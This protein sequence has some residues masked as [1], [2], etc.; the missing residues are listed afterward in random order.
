[1]S[2]IHQG[3]FS[4]PEIINDN[5][6]PFPFE[7][8]PIMI[9]NYCVSTQNDIVFEVNGEVT[10]FSKNIF[11][12]I[13]GLENVNEVINFHEDGG[14][15]VHITLTITV[16]ETPSIELDFTTP[17]LTVAIGGEVNVQLQ[18][19]ENTIK[20]VFSKQGYSADFGFT[21]YVNNVLLQK[22][23]IFNN[24]NFINHLG[25]RF[26]FDVTLT[27]GIVSGISGSMMKYDINREILRLPAVFRN[28]KLTLND[29]GA[30]IGFIT[31][32]PMD[33][34][35]FQTAGVINTNSYNVKIQNFTLVTTVE[36]EIFPIYIALKLNE[37]TINEI[38]RFFEIT[39]V[40]FPRIP[41]SLK[42]PSVIWSEDTQRLPNGTTP[43]KGLS[44]SSLLSFEN[45]NIFAAFNHQG[46]TLDGFLQ[47][48]GPIHIAIDNFSLLELN[49]N[50]QKLTAS[51]ASLQDIPTTNMAL[52][53]QKN[54]PE[55]VLCNPGGAIFEADTT[56]GNLKANGNLKLFGEE[57]AILD[58]IIN[59]RDGISGLIDLKEARII[60]EKVVLSIVEHT[61]A[62]I[63]F[64]IGHKFNFSV[65]HIESASFEISEFDIL[66]KLSETS[67]KAEVMFNTQYLGELDTEVVLDPENNRNISDVIDN[68]ITFIANNL[69][70]ILQ[71]V[72]TSPDALV[73]FV[74]N[75]ILIPTSMPAKFAI[76]VLKKMGVPTNEMSHYL[77]EMEHALA[78]N[79]ENVSEAI[80]AFYGDNAQP[81][82][83]EMLF[84]DKLGFSPVS[85][86]QALENNFK[87]PVKEMTT[88]LHNAGVKA[89]ETAEALKTVFQIPAAEIAC[90]MEH[91]NYP[92][93]VIESAFGHLGGTFE[94]VYK[95]I[96]EHIFSWDWF[97]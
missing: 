60:E 65:P 27:D 62:S 23:R 86:A 6:I 88:I 39:N 43:K 26:N 58:V 55:V 38:L 84:S 28:L 9:S 22:E 42:Q 77:S 93:Q 56:Q 49:G 30:T 36:G 50:G 46:N 18:Q 40:Y 72:F 90:M 87:I 63:E 20:I 13:N 69:P 94:S 59:E 91:A 76:E 7:V 67:M 92:K 14:F 82:L 81:I 1:M 11:G 97:Q 31:E 44:F 54:T 85:I 57:I 83:E 15:S 89:I 41:V 48:D 33:L 78:L 52:N 34:I 45:L 68:I 21:A 61:S 5:K 35:G 75:R 96:E 24:W 3:I 95:K 4:L 37:L 29:L 79:A 16:G 70:K 19:P 73:S 64:T 12:L 2:N 80:I 53:K 10:K 51:A 25:L 32:P 8:P 74:I 66:L 71:Q 47:V 17:S